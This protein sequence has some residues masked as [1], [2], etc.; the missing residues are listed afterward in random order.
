MDIRNAFR[1][2]VVLAA[3]IGGVLADAAVAQ[4]PAAP[5]NLTAIPNYG[6]GW[7]ELGWRDN[8]NNELGFEIHR[9]T[10]GGPFMK[11]LQTGPNSTAI[12][13]AAVN[14]TDEYVYAVAAFNAAGLSPFAPVK[15]QNLKTLWPVPASHEVLHNWNET[16]GTAGVGDGGATTGFHRGVDI[17]RTGAN[18]DV[19]ACRGGLVAATSAVANGYVIVRVKVGA[20][21]EFDEYNHLDAAIPVAV[22]AIVKAGDKIGR[23]DQT[24]IF[25]DGGGNVVN[26]VDHVHFDQ[27]ATLLGNAITRHPLLLFKANADKDPQEANPG[28]QHH[29]G[30]PAGT[31]LFR[32]NT[33]GGPYLPFSA[34]EPLFGDLDII[35]EISDVLG[36]NPDHVPQLLAY[37]I[38]PPAN[39]ACTRYAAVR[40]ADVPYVL[41]D[42]S[43][44]YFGAGQANTTFMQSIVD[45][46]QD[47]GSALVVGGQQYPWQNFKHFIITN[48]KKASGTA[49]DV[50]ATQYWNSNAKSDATAPTA[51]TANFAGKP[52]ATN[53]GNARFPDGTY[54]IKIRLADLIHTVVMSQAVRIEN[55]P[56]IVCE[57]SPTIDLP[58]TTTTAQGY[59]LFNEA[60]DTPLTPANTL[61]TIDKGATV[62]GQQWSGDRWLAY[63]LGNLKKNTRYIVTIKKNA[64]DLPG[65]PG[66]NQLDGNKDGTAGDDFTYSFFVKP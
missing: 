45:A 34:L 43:R 22:N 41:F 27:T 14:T 17:Q 13:D 19:V 52:D 21:F 60:M 12:G 33:A 28:L 32:N 15:F 63:S 46:N 51:E 64:R 23:I 4:V 57:A 10:N 35:A 53:G 24:G 38:E 36:T 62:T 55:F 61:V 54:T 42:W 66:S 50:D 29:V 47:Y 9:S 18:N 16:I 65:T 30:S 8:S 25:T 6:A 11:V 26:F 59:V 39:Q 58:N 5:S 20:A 2:F 7:I 48:T 3:A 49:G 44:R 40:N 31:F 37:W 1:R 56:P